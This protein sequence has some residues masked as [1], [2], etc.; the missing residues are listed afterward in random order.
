[1]SNQD[2]K[3]RDPEIEINPCPTC[4]AKPGRK[5]Q[6][7]LATGRVCLW[8]R[9]IKVDYYHAARKEAARESRRQDSR[10]R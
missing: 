4:W 6:K 5:C 10:Y 1:M 3:I 9:T 8:K 2:A 7:T